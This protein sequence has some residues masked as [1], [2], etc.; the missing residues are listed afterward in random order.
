MAYLVLVAFIAGVVWIGMAAMRGVRR[1]TE[2][3]HAMG[4]GRARQPR[5]KRRS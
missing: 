5:R 3:P 2:A 4:R 1:R